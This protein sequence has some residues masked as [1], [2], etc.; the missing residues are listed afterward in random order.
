MKKKIPV[1]TVANA[2]EAAG[3]TE[4]PGEVRIALAE[5]AQ[6]AKYGLSGFCADVGLVVM[7]EMMVAELTERIGPK[8][9]HIPGREANWHGDTKG[10]VVLGDRLVAME[11]P[12][13]RYVDGGEM[14]LESWRVFSST[15]LLD[16]LTVERMLAGV[17]T[18]RHVDVSVPTTPEIDEAAA[19]T[20]K[21]SVSRRFHR[22]TEAKLAELMARDL[23]GYEVAVMMIDGVDVAGQCCVVALAITTDGVKIPVGLWLGDTENHRVVTDLLADLVARG[24]SDDGGILFALDGAKALAKAVR[25]VF[26]DDTLI[27]RCTIHK[28]R[29]VAG[30]LP[31]ELAGTIDWRLARAFANPDPAKGLDQARRLAAELQADHPDAAGSLREGLED[32]FT[33]RRLGITGTLLKSITTTNPIESM[34]SIVRTTT[35][36]VKNWKDGEMKKRWI[37]TGMLEAE[38]SFRRVK[39]CKEMDALV[40]ALRHHAKVT[41]SDYDQAA[42]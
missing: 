1:V 20:A 18:R 6:S 31:A 25:K 15:D 11:R 38:R 9:A 2:E 34:I 12:R 40:T 23:S 19:G 27:Q 8:G 29:N 32:M 14:E 35:R 7:Y 30:Y 24:L 28:R 13:G 33:V 41:P 4:L 21:S 39:G 37:A 16:Q 3:L 17:A 22:A 36:N 42:A 5:V 26:G 10:K